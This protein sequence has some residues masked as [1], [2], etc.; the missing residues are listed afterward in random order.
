[1]N[2]LFLG[3]FSTYPIRVYALRKCSLSSQVMNG[4]C[5]FK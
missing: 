3:L 2:D 5:A 1:M 4:G